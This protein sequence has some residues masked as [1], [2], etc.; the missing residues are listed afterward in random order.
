MRKT[1]L[2]L[3]AATT[4]LGLVAAGCGDGDDSDEAVE[5]DSGATSCQDVDLSSPPA[6]PVNIRFGY[7]VG[8]EEP[9][10]LQFA[11]PEVAGARHYDSWYTVDANRFQPPDRLAAYQAGDLDAGT[12]STA[13]LFTA[14]NMGLEIAAVGAIATVS[15]SADFQFPYLAADGSGIDS[16]ED[17]EGKSIGIIAP[18]TATEYWAISAVEQAGLDP[19]RDVS[20]VA[21]PPPNAE[22]V[23]RDGQVDVEFFLP[24]FLPPDDAGFH[25]VFDALTGTGFEHD[26]LDVW[27][28]RG[29]IEE[30]PEVYCAWR[31]DYQSSMTAYL[32]DRMAAAEALLSQDLDPAPS[33]EAFVNRPDVGRPADGVIDLDGMQMLIDDMKE[34]GFLPPNLDITAE[35]LVLEGFSLAE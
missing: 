32:E 1:I 33:V 25:E 5:T 8:Q 11:D 16:P 23:L 9:V 15:E 27:F 12:I 31:A 34:I 28:D 10:Y 18:N 24:D 14:V 21:I 30:N 4:A 29:F 19:D 20:F 3:L 35:D 7:G 2:R 17:L 26:F 13:Q 6:E 22:Q